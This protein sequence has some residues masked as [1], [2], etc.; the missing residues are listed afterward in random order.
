HYQPVAQRGAQEIVSRFVV[1]GQG[2][3]AVQDRVALEVSYDVIE[4]GQMGHV[5]E[6]EKLELVVEVLLPAVVENHVALEMGRDAEGGGGV[7]VDVVDV[8]AAVVR[9]QGGAGFGRFLFLV[10]VGNQMEISGRNLAREKVAVAIFGHAEV[11]TDAAFS[12]DVDEVA[13]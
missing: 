5:F 12:R 4:R 2:E 13:V 7:V 11:D 3:D 1:L 6:F 10:G 9:D 8:G